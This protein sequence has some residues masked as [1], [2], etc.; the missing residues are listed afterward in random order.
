M[1]S[2][3]LRVGAPKRPRAFVRGSLDHFEFLESLFF[4]WHTMLQLRNLHVSCI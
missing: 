4:I 3:G 2:E 1:V